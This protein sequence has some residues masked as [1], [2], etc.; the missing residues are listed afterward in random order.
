VILPAP[1]G[2]EV[3]ADRG[4]RRIERHPNKRYLIG[5]PFFPAL[6]R[7]TLVR[8][9][10]T[11]RFRR[12]PEAVAVRCAHRSTPNQSCGR[13][14]AS[15]MRHMCHISHHTGRHSTSLRASMTMNLARG[16]RLAPSSRTWSVA[17]YRAPR[18]PVS[19]RKPIAAR[20]GSSITLGNCPWPVTVSVRR[21]GVRRTA[22]WQWRGML[23][24]RS[25]GRRRSL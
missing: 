6:D 5:D 3:E 13:S 12:D 14:S 19:R 16:W 20:A 11:V 18:R 8:R 23:I 24:E 22:A 7:P 25:A 4:R 9:S 17:P 10:R 15:Q 21:Q 2:V 1:P